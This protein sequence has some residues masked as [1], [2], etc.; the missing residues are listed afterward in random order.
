MREAAAAATEEGAEAEAEAAP[1]GRGRGGRD[2]RSDYFSAAA[3]ARTVA[4]GSGSAGLRVGLRG[5]SSSPAL[6]CPTARRRTTHGARASGTS[7]ES[8]IGRQRR[9]GRRHGRGKRADALLPGAGIT[10]LHAFQQNP[11]RPALQQP[12]GCQ[13]HSAGTG[14]AVAV[15]VPH[16]LRTPR[17]AGPFPAVRIYSYNPR[18]E[19]AFYKKRR[20]IILAQNRRSRR[21]V[22]ENNVDS[23]QEVLDAFLIYRW[24][25]L[26]LQEMTHGYP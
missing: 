12:D 8:S 16:G 3:A 4:A 5:R 18:N 9:R 23:V 15:A 24:L 7:K 14:A 13:G 26:K 21:N 10:P 11:P 17:V 22:R 6:G 2:H 20:L 25:Q 19:I 1:S